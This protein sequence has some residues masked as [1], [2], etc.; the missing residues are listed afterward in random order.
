VKPSTKGR[1]NAPPKKRPAPPGTPICSHCGEYAWHTVSCYK[2]EIARGF[3]L[4]RVVRY[5]REEEPPVCNR[6]I[7]EVRRLREWQQTRERIADEKVS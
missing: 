2:R 7:D 3:F 5:L 4:A 6:C 1:H